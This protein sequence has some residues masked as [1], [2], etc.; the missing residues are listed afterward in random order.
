LDVDE[1]VIDLRVRLKIIVAQ[2]EVDGEPR[3]EL[4][5]V[6]DVVRLPPVPEVRRCVSRVDARVAQITQHEIRQ[7]ASG[8]GSI[9]AEAAARRTCLLEGH[10]PL[11]DIG[12]GF[13]EVRTAL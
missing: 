11:C 3:S 10:L 2:A 7:S 8:V 5:V 9:E 12:A 1:L 13:K 4:P 6:V